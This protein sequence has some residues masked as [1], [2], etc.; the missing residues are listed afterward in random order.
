MTRIDKDQVCISN[1]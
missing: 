1:I